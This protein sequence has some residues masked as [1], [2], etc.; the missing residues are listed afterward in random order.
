MADALGPVKEVTLDGRGALVSNVSTFLGD[1]SNFTTFLDVITDN[2]GRIRKRPGKGSAKGASA[3]S[4]ITQMHEYVFTN[5][6]SGAVTCWRLRTFGTSIQYDNAGVWTAMTLPYVPAS[7]AWVFV[8]AKNKVFAVN[9][10][11]DAIFFDG[12]G[13]TWKA[14]GQ[15][16]PGVTMTYS[17]GG[18]VTDVTSGR[19]VSLTNGSPTVTASG[20][21]FTTGGAWNNLYMDINGIRYQILSV[22]STTVLTLTA[23]FKEATAAGLPWKVYTGFM[24]WDIA[25]KYAY[26]YYN[27]TTG[28]TSNIRSAATTS[29]NILQLTEANQIGVTPTVTIPG[30][31]ANT[32][33]YNAGYTQFKI[34]R[35]PVNGNI[36]VAIN[37]TVNNVNTGAAINFTENSGTYQDT[38]L[39]TFEAPLVSNAKPV[40]GL[41]SI[42]W[43]QGRLVATTRLGIQYSA[44]D[45]EISIGVA[46][47]C[48]PAKYF[49]SISEPLGL[50]TI[51]GTG[52]SDALII[53]TNSGLWSLDGNDVRTFYPYGLPGKKEGSA[54]GNAAVAGTSLVTWFTDKQLIDYGSDEDLGIPIQD[55]LDTIADSLVRT[56]RVFRFT[57]KSRDYLFVSVPKTGGSTDNDY[58]YVLNRKLGVWYEWNLGFTAFARVHNSSTGAVELWAGDSTGNVYQLLGS[59]VQDSAGNFAPTFTTSLIR[60][61]GPEVEA[62]LLFVKAWVSDGTNLPSMKLFINENTNTGA[63][64]G[65]VT[66]ATLLVATQEFQSAQ[67]RLIMWTPSTTVRNVSDVF[68]FLLTM[69]SLNADYYFDRITYV[70]QA[71]QAPDTPA[72]A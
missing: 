13:T 68:Q 72:R 24:T 61:F 69:P 27:P 54:Q 50:V 43:Y 55:K 60:P 31:A 46:E 58:T 28:H 52:G 71:E 37:A 30:N 9:G 19:T 32:T 44:I 1:E 7:S 53:Q 29:S 57:H 41:V 67:G 45:P 12:S 4:R 15:D 47:E 33:A 20:A 34:Y 36:L 63:T 11:D 26:S 64:D 70:F 62:R 3:G 59:A 40:T 23:N 14:V 38:A 22:T 66:T 18:I 39:T 49:L 65:T 6:T 25:P 56:V 48:W 35:T 8:N 17:L 5:P 42:A 2:A 21:A 51:G 16:G 10:A